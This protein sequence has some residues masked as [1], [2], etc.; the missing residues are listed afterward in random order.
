MTLKVAYNSLMCCDQQFENRRLKRIRVTEG[1]DLV[2]EFR[3]KGLYFFY[4]FIF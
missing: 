1:S 3:A 2:D 4:L